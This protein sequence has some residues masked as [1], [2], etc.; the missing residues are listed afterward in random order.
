M[1]ISRRTM[2]AGTASVA[3]AGTLKYAGAQTAEFNYKYANNL[4]LTH[5]MNKRAQE[6]VEKIRE[7]TSGRVSIQI[8]PNNQLGA[9][10]DMLSQVRSGGVEFFTLSPLILSTLVPNASISGMGF[11]FPNYDA[12]W[13]AMDGDLGKYV[14]GEIEKANLVVMDKIWDNGFRQITSSTGPIN[15]ADDL[16]GFKIRVPVS[17]LW[18]SMFKAF[19]S[20]P[21]SINFAEVYS[22]LQ[23]KIVDGQEN[24]LAIIA[25]A[26]LYEVQQYCSLTN[27]MWDGF[28]FLA[29]RRAWQRLPEDLRT[30]VAKNLNDAAVKERADVAALNASLQEELTGKGMKFNKPEPDSFRKKL[31]D[32]GFYAEWKSK[33]GDEAWAIFEKAI[34][35]A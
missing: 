21:A 3:F 32:A 24:P 35:P 9:D 33:Y 6:A 25:T 8:F 7:E 16:K 19:E 5:P 29:N 27:H 20:A 17:P 2:L 31:R 22:A 12:V 26:K 11:A 30:I 14:R 15:T 23:T 18:T 4:P 10:T 28:W 13:H 1:K 34:S